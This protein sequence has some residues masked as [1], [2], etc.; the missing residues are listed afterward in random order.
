M[1]IDNIEIARHNINYKYSKML[2]GGMNYVGFKIT[3]QK[4][5]KIPVGEKVVG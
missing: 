2:V 3:R 5:T 1:L 4:N